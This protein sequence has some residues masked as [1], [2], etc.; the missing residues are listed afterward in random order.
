MTSKEAS[1]Y[2]AREAQ[3]AEIRSMAVSSP[4]E[5]RKQKKRAEKLNTMSNAIRKLFCRTYNTATYRFDR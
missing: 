1:E 3:K 2:Y 5:A 4:A